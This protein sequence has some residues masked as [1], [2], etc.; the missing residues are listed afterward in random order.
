M[1]GTIAPTD[2]ISAEKR[3]EQRNALIASFLGWTL[4]A[5][6]FFIVVMVLTEI[7]RDFKRSYAEQAFTLSVTLAFR[8]VGAFIFGLLADRYGRRIPLMIDVTFYS[9]IEI[10]SGLAPNYCPPSTISSACLIVASVMVLPPSMRA[11]SST[12]SFS[13][14]RR[15]SAVVRSFFTDLDTP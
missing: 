2:P 8:P 10:A 14:S 7:S 1:P 12:R 15:T 13:S 6:D 3:K 5:F 11:I 9:V 4:D